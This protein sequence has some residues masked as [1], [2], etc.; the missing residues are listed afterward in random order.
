[1][2]GDVAVLARQVGHELTSLRRTPITLILSVG[3]PLVFF[4]LIAALIGNEVLDARSGVRLAQFVAPAFASFG[5]VMATFSFLAVGFAEARASGV[6]KRQAGTPLPRWALLGGRIGA[7][8]L[9]GLIATALVLGVGVAFYDVQ[10]IGRTL[11]A[12]VVTLV[13]ASMS[14][15]ALGLALAVLLPTPQATLAV[16]NG[17]VIPIAFFSDIFFFGSAAPAWMATIGWAFPLKHLVNAFGDAL[18]PF[19][20]GSGFYLDHLVVIAAWGVAGALVAARGLRSERERVGGGKVRG[21]RGSGRARDLAPRRAARAGA[22]AL[23]RDQVSHTNAI[24]WRDASSV[25]FAVAFPV[26]LVA[27]IPTANGGGGQR[28][29][30]GMLLGA[31]FAATMAVYGAAVTCYVNMPQGLAEARDALVLK[32]EHATPLPLWALLVGRGVGAV[33]VAL[34]TLAAVWGLATVMYRVPL[35]PTWP[36]ALVT[37]LAS[38]TC[39]AVLGLA[40]VALVRSAQALIGVAL[41]TLLP[42]SFISDV[43]VVGAAFPPVLD[44]AAWVFPLRHATRA[45]TEAAAAGSGFAPGHLAV[46]AAWTLAGLAVIVWRFSWVPRDGGRRPVAKGARAEGSAAS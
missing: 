18:N 45:M 15:S 16:T 22:F 17:L 29:P 23:L 4:V 9:L 32:R 21:R 8:L 5:V 24:L 2:R 13:V 31:F 44:G 28:L 46:L 43:F 11:P 40:L 38:T 26:L 10:I 30:N 34:L 6:L 35:P 20:A 19:L 41:G 27:I 39:F 1:V 7:A 25:F 37:F 3:F 36:A 42:L 12:V 14:F 33:W